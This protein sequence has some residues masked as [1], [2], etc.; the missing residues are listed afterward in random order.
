MLALGRF[1]AALGLTL[2]ALL[3]AS[4]NSTP[5]LPLPPPLAT[6][7]TPDEQGF[8]LVEGEATEQAYVSI[9]NEATDQ[10]VITQ[11]DGEGKYSARIV[12]KSKDRL[13]IWQTVE[14]ETSELKYVYVPDPR[15]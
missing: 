2:T 1:V 6:V 9:L 13:T 10:G 5:T 4:C 3:C 12:A 14:G 8:A 7:S 11:A 15:P